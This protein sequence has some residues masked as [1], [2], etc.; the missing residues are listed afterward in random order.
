MTRKERFELK[1]FTASALIQ[2]PDHSCSKAGALS[3]THDK[4]FFA[5]ESGVCNIDKCT[6]YTWEELHSKDI[7]AVKYAWAQSVAAK[8]KERMIDYFI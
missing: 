5:D 4:C 6:Q 1:L 3:C 7:R 2:S 8:H